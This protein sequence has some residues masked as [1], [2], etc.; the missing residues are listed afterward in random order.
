MFVAMLR[1]Q[2]P[3]ILC[4]GQLENNAREN[5]NTRRAGREERFAAAFL[6]TPKVC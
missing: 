6:R 3:M 5:V 2:R 4:A 1:G